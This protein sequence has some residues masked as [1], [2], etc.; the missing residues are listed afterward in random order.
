LLLVARAGNPTY[1]SPDGNYFLAGNYL[2]V[3]GSFPDQPSFVLTLQD[4]T[5]QNLYANVSQ[6][7]FIAGSDT[8]T[9]DSYG[10][11]LNNVWISGAADFI[12]PT[13]MIT[14]PVAGQR[15]SNAVFTVTGKARDNVAVT[16]V[17]CSVNGVWSSAVT[18]NHWT[19]WTAQVALTPGTNSLAS[20]A[21]DSSGNVSATNTVAL[22]YV[23][24]AVVTVNVGAGGTVTPNDNGALLQLG[25]NYTLTAKTN[26]GFAFAGWTGSIVTNSALLTFQMTSNLVLNANFVDVAK[27]TNAITAPVNGQRWSNVVFTVTGRA[28]DNVAVSNVFCSLNHGVWSSAVTTNHWSTWT[29]LVTLTP[30]TNVISAY[31]VDTSGNVSITSTVRVDYVASALLTVQIVGAGTVTPNLNGQLLAIGQNY[32]MTAAASNGFA[33][34]F[35]GWGVATNA[36]SMTN[37][38][39]LGFN[40]ASNLVIVAHFVDVAKPTNG[41]GFPTANQKWSNSV[42]SVTGKAGDNVGVAGVWYQINQGGWAPAQTAN[43]Y[44]NW[45]AQNLPV[46]LGTNTLQ[47]YA[48]DA[49]GNVSTTNVL[50]FLGVVAPASL[51]GYAAILKPSVGTQQVAFA[52]GDGTYSQA[53]VGSD[54]NADDY[55]AG[56]FDY[57]PTSSNTALITNM[58]VGMLSALGV[59]NVT[60]WNVTFTNPTTATYVWTNAPD[61]GAGTMTILPVGNLVPA[62]L[63]GKTIKIYQG[64]ALISTIV[65]NTGG[66]F[67]STNK[68][69]SHNGTY[70]FVQYS[71]T[72]VILHQDFTDGSNAGGS[73][74]LE[75]NFSSTTAGQAF[76]SYYDQPAYGGS[77]ND[78]AVGTFT[79]APTP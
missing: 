5:T 20:Y 10:N 59:T 34:Y 21:V 76:G 28:G 15:C 36:M 3:G 65:L 30:G 62:T 2:G 41:I 69:G 61:S 60:V 71:P 23:L 33:F 12:A 75:L 51:A 72:V 37:N 26:A 42:I 22:V 47:A 55:G 38:K 48:M 11:A 52:W 70:D 44:T 56:V 45:S 68:N 35:W 43:G 18:A 54:T 19:N 14:S 24:S 17:F 31:A 1:L 16:N 8:V 67:N 74:Y 7:I 6:P 13:N 9:Q 64:T 29:A 50:K 66:T 73:Q 63:A 40:M 39:T 58:D 25:Q 57:V 53:G 27:P 4:G 32:S 79:I 49:A 78:T 46:T 77:P